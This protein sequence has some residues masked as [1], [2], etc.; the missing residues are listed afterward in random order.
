MLMAAPFPGPRLPHYAI[1]LQNAVMM[2]ILDK[3]VVCFSVLL[4]L[5]LFFLFSFYC[6]F[7]TQTVYLS[8]YSSVPKPTCRHTPYI[9]AHSRS[10]ACSSR[11]FCRLDSHQRSLWLHY[12][13]LNVEGR[14]GASINSILSTVDE[15]QD[16]QTS[17][18]T[19][20]HFHA[21]LVDAPRGPYE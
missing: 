8:R 3:T 5:F 15:A 4:H 11:V 16:T 19:D 20:T 10:V 14:S 6:C 2:C 17:T 12:C 9:H 7:K 18:H 13:Y 1:C 21:S